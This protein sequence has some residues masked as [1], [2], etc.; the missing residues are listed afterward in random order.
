MSGVKIPNLP[1]AVTPLSGAE[2]VPLEQGTGTKKVTVSDIVAL[3]A[4]GSGPPGPP[5][6]P[7][8]PGAPGVPGPP[9]E[10]GPAGPPGPAGG[11]S[12]TKLFLSVQALVQD[13]TLTYSAGSDYTVAAGDGIRT[14]LDGFAY[15]VAA[16][17]ATDHHLVT[18][19]GVKLYCQPTSGGF[20]N[21]RSINPDA[22]GV[23]DCWAKLEALIY[24]TPRQ[25]GNVASRV[26]VAPIYFPAGTY[27]FDAEFPINVQV[28]LFGPIG[29]VNNDNKQGADIRFKANTAGFI[30]NSSNT[31]NGTVI[32]PADTTGAGSTFEGLSINSLTPFNGGSNLGKH[33]IQL[34]ATANIRDCYINFFPGNGIHMRT[35][36]SNDPEYTLEI[37]GNS[38]LTKLD[39]VRIWSCKGSGVY[40]DGN[41]CNACVGTGI[42]ASLNWEWGIFD[43]STLGNTWVGCHTAANGANI[44]QTGGLNARGTVNT[45]YALYGGN[46]YYAMPTMTAETL[47]AT[48]PGSAGSENVWRSMTNTNTSLAIE[49]TPS[50]PVGTYRPGGAYYSDNVNARSAWINCY[51]ESG[52]GLTFFAQRNVVLNGLLAGSADVASGAGVFGESGHL[53]ASSSGSAGIGTINRTDR[54]NNSDRRGVE[55]RLGGNPGNGDIMFWRGQNTAGLDSGIVRCHRDNTNLYG[56]DGDAWLWDHNGLFTSRLYMAFTGPSN[57]RP[58]RA[59]FPGLVLGD[60]TTGRLIGRAA[61]A[62]VSGTYAI[63]DIILATAPV[64][65]GSNKFIGWVCTVAGTPGTWVAFGP[66]DPIA[67]AGGGVDDAELLAIAGLTS[68]ADTLPYFTG[69]GTAALASFTS[70]ARTLVDD[71][72]AAAVRNTLGLGGLSTVAPGSG[73][74]T[75]AGNEVNSSGGFVTFGAAVGYPTGA[76]SLVEQ[77]TSRTTAVTINKLCGQIKLVSASSSY[78]WTSFTVQNNQVSATDVVI[79]SCGASTDVYAVLVTKVSDGSF[80]LTFADLTTGL[81][82]EQPVFNFAVVKA[83]NS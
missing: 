65:V 41:N 24:K 75:A 60:N 82:T 19:G 25:V 45:A 32:S 80:V 4:G 26:T 21:F 33:G 72:D 16:S 14:I 37:E 18:V 63:G 15:A 22:T 36:A 56:A 11:G 5:G 48:T 46:I 54:Y 81:T 6:P 79:A 55:V 17:G 29:G 34:R 71:A 3:A 7:G 57:S 43:G 30:V 78:S 66:L 40:V 2:L 67:G 53:Y 64:T 52:Q 8:T 83:V 74:V 39:N 51:A 9:G 69:S 12:E 73:V 28:K 20:Y 42:D 62:P 1:A 35:S 50:R 68:A 70:F 13:A 59:L 76:G 61:A 58:Y 27:Y 38:N 49:W 31:R 44:S 23:Q 77:T 47:S 10:Q